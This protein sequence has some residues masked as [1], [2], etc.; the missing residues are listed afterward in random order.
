MSSQ[1]HALRIQSSV[2]ISPPE[3]AFRGQRCPTK[4]II[5]IS[6]PGCHR[7]HPCSPVLGR[8][9]DEIVTFFIIDDQ[10][11]RIVIVSKQQTVSSRIP[12]NGPLGHCRVVRVTAILIIKIWQSVGQNKESS[13]MIR[14][15]K[16]GQSRGIEEI[17]SQNHI[18]LR[19]IRPQGS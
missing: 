4:I 13:Q 14:G 7:V 18:N 11:D 1:L 16:E 2:P 8:P 9:T 12:G 5:S 3:T 15:I 17:S 6:N 10:R 19:M